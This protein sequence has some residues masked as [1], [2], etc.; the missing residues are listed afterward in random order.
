MIARRRFRRLQDLMIWQKSIVMRKPRRFLWAVFLTLLLKVDRIL[1]LI[2]NSAQ[3]LE[4]FEKYGKVVECQI[5]KDREN[6]KPRGFGFVTF[7]SEDSVEKVLA[8][9]KEHKLMDKW[10]DCKK[11]IP[12]AAPS[13]S[14]L[15][16]PSLFVPSRRKLV[17]FLILLQ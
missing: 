16:K 12:K 17:F 1:I 10:V 4:H 2:H 15:S 13:P 5:M 11:A 6:G 9:L 8:N 14:T 3:I 7:E